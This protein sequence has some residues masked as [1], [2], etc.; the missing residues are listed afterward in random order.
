[1]LRLTRLLP[2]AALLGMAL[3]ARLR[4]QQPSIE[5][6]PYFGLYMP[7]T[8]VISQFEPSCP[9]DV[10]LKHQPAF[11]VGTRVLFWMNRRFGLEAAMAYSASGVRAEASGI[12]AADTAAEVVLGTARLVARLNHPDATTAFLAGAGLGAVAHGGDFYDL[13][14]ATGTTDLGASVMVGVRSQIASRLMVRVELEDYL[15][16]ASFGPS[17]NTNSQFQHDLVASLGLG[18]LLGGR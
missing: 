9:C 15:Y 10:S 13:A 8:S 6:T 18:V 7:T 12:G 5:I 4:S 3:P 14:G 11:L 1:M 2:L 17:P 16:S